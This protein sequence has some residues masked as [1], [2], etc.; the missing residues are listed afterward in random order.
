MKGAVTGLC[1]VCHKVKS[2]CGTV[3]AAIFKSGFLRWHYLV[4][5]SL[6]CFDGREDS[7]GVV[8]DVEVSEN[9]KVSFCSIGQLKCCF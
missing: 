4:A 2:V 7:A 9:Q 3:G 1:Y 6:F 8:L 5:Q